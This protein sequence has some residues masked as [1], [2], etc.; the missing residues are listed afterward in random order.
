MGLRDLLV[1]SMIG[2]WFVAS[3][4]ST[5]ACSCAPPGTPL[6]ARAE[7]ELV[8]RGTV[9]SIRPSDEPGLL[10]ID[11]DVATVWRGQRAETIS[12]TTQQDTAACGY[13]F[14]ERVE[15]LVYSWNGVDV[16]R[17]GR[18]APIDQAGEDL[19]AF[20]AGAQTGGIADFPNTGSGGLVKAETTHDRA[21]A[22]AGVV[23]VGAILLGVVGTRLYVRRQDRRSNATRVE[24]T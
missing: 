20:G 5:Y 21:A 22:I 19:A 9:T 11:F 1:V 23:A 6:E 15:Y 3:P 7:S 14:E 17:C 12:L 24:R 2:L 8:F 13:P 10:R 16:A 4:T 18:T